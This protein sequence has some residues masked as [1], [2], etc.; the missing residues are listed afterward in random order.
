MKTVT[1]VG[2]GLAGSETAWQLAKRGIKVRL[3]EMRPEKMTPAHHTGLFAELV[4]SNSLRSNLLENAAGLLK[5]EM[6]RLDSLIIKCADNNTVPAGS[7]LA[8]DREGFARQVTRMIEENP[9]IEVI[10]QEVTEFPEGPAIIATGPLTSDGLAK[11]LA[12]VLDCEYLYFYDAASPIVTAESLDMDVI[13][14]ASRYGKAGDHYLNCPFTS[15][16]YERFWSELVEAKGY[17]LKQFENLKVF[18]GCMPVEVMAKRGKDTLLYGP[19]RPVGLTDP[20]TGR[21]PYAVVQLRQDNAQGTLYNLVG[22]QTNLR[23]SEQNRVFRM[24][25]GLKDA[26]FVRYGVMHRN[27]YINSPRLMLD[28]L[29]LRADPGI[30]FAGQ[31]TGVEGYIES[32]ASGLVAG[33]GMARLLRG[34]PPL[35]LPRETIIGSLIKYITTST[36]SDGFQ[37]MNANFGLLPPLEG[38]VKDKKWRNR[39]LAERSLEYLDRIVRD[40]D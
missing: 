39:M 28:T 15:E 37:P 40:L 11:T 14:R 38:R 36:A 18:E 1:V 16:E 33:I 23:W 25:P 3:Y 13:F 22:F 10:R 4:C 31:I 9:N 2:A 20:R 12:K 5:E 19:L 24:I 17:P 21:T 29:Q 27:T 32:T 30:M 7:A 8:V 26:E 6:R 34:K 35:V